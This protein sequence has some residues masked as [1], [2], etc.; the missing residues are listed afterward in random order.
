MSPQSRREFLA[1][2]GALTAFSVM[3]GAA[4]FSARDSLTELSAAEAVSMIQHGDI[5]AEAYSRALLDR[6]SQ[7]RDLNAFISMDRDAV[8]EAAQRIDQERN[9]G[10]QLGVLAGLPVPLKDSIGTTSLPTTCGTRSL[11]SF[12]PK[13]DA[14]VWQR[15]SQGGAILLGK[16][17]LHE[18]SLGWTSANQAYGPVRNPYDPS[19]I[20]GG[21]SGGT[22]V[23]VSARMAP[24]GI[25]EDTNGSIRVPAAMCG[26]AGLR[27]THGRYPSAGVMPLAPSL[28]TVGPMARRVSDLCLLDSVVTGDPIV[29]SPMELNGVRFGVSREHYFTNLDS[30]VQQVIEAVLARLRDA[31]AVIV[32]AEIPDLAALTGKVTVALVYYEARRSISRFLAEQDAPV[33]FAGLVSELSPEIRKQVDDWVVEGAP[34]EI[35]EQAYRDAIEKYRPALQE[36]WR[37]FFAEHRVA[38]VISPVVRMPAPQLPQ[39]LT[40]PGFDVEINGTVVP[41][42]VAFARNIAPSSSAGLPSV[43]LPAGM[44][45]G[46][47]IGIELDGPVASDRDLLSL[48]LAV[49][50]VIHLNL[51][52]KI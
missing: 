33:D 41:A 52:P 43:V 13:D 14:A 3:P 5:R 19:R 46:L 6:C 40:S 7:L 48:A 26:I 44:V 28:D 39:S 9:R 36:T 30:S 29:T 8:L 51:A 17:N 11:R 15:L 12:R 2:T 37:S 50:R 45:S 34:N 47:P 20:P 16:T 38:A 32:E 27:P 35:S 25:G 24:A 21:S 1:T 31:G 42:R 10:K 49:E 4:A 23:A 18:M 22:A